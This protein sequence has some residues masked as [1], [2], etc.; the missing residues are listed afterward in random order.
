MKYRLGIDLGTSYFKFGI[1]DQ[2]LNLKGL[3]RVAVE[4]DTSNGCLCEIPSTRFIH[5]LRTGINH[6]CEQTG[7]LPAQIDAIGYSSQANSFLLLGENFTP[8]SPIILWPDNRVGKLYAEVEQLWNAKMF[9]KKTGIGI[10]PPPELCI[11]KLLWFKYNR[12]DTWKNVRHVMT[13]SDYLTFLFTGEKTGD[14]GTASLLGLLDCETKE[15]WPQSFEILDLDI[16]LF[17]KRSGISTKLGKT[18]KT[19]SDLFGFREKVFLYAGSLDHYMAALGAGL[20]TKADLSISI[21]TVLACVNFTNRYIPQKDVCISPW[22]NN[23]FCQLAFDENGA[24]SLEWYKNNFAPCHSIE[25]L[26]KMALEV[27]D[28]DELIAKPNAYKYSSL[29]VAF[30]NIKSHHTHGHFIYAIME[31]TALTLKNLVDKLCPVQKP[32]KSV[33]TGGGAQ[34]ELWLKICSEKLN[35]RIFRAN[36]SEPATKG[37]VIPIPQKK[38]TPR[39]LDFRGPE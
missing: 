20:D 10:T 4:K 22:K 28:S 34:S 32:E 12:P 3:G 24:V 27:G 14:T 15:Y 30:K 39:I 5:L 8:L 26:K 16:I 18:N 23:Q 2:N 29:E 36:C 37:A 31:S 21:G 35:S 33:A 7:I 38:C 13:I 17:A 1:Y 9:L 6:A 19:G 25:E 11:N